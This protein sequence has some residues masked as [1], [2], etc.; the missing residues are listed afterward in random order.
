MSES[1]ACPNCGAVAWRREWEVNQPTKWVAM[2]DPESQSFLPADEVSED[3]DQPDTHY[4]CEACEF[5]VE[6]G[7]LYDALEE[8]AQE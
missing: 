5:E 6:G 8:C 3:V 7:D 4:F 1:F 2:F